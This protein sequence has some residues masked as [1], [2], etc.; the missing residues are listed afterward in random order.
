MIAPNTVVLVSEQRTVSPRSSMS[1]TMYNDLVNQTGADLINIKTQLNRIFEGIKTGSDVTKV[2]ADNTNSSSSNHG[3]D[4]TALYWDSSVAG[5]KQSI[6]EYI[7]ALS[8]ALTAD[9]RDTTAAEISFDPT[10]LD[11]GWA[12]FTDVQ[13]AL[14]E[15]IGNLDDIVAA[16]FDGGTF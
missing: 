3:I 1:S 14:F 15:T 7:N 4:A 11:S 8:T 2:W 16:T 12:T 5:T 10:G 9:L 13:S 6:Y